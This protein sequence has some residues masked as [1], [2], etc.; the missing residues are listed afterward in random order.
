MHFLGLQ[1][2][3]LLALFLSRV[4]VHPAGAASKQQQ[5]QQSVMTKRIGN[6]TFTCSSLFLMLHKADG[7]LEK[8]RDYSA[9][10]GSQVNVTEEEK[11][12][13]RVLEL[14]QRELRAALTTLETVLKDLNQ[15][16]SGDYHSLDKLKKSCRVDA[17]L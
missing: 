12:K 4:G 6:S 3:I 1:E 14:Y 16:V 7:T 9:R 10:I 8:L 13:A 2:A 17:N 15:T 11:V 5:Q